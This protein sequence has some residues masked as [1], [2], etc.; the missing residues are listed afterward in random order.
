MSFIP[1]YTVGYVVPEAVELGARRLRK[2][3]GDAA[4]A[5]LAEF[6]DVKADVT[7]DYVEVQWF[8]VSTSP[9]T[10]EMLIALRDRAQCDIVDLGHRHFVSKLQ[11]GDAA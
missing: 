8:G 7:D 9:R 11:G 2:P 4:R 1:R 10:R 5:V 3:L 6:Q